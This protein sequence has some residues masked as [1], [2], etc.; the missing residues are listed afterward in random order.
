MF[1]EA[2]KI[3]LEAFGIL[4]SALYLKIIPMYS[5]SKHP[6]LPTRNEIQENS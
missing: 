3:R 5:M 1:K 6:K 4:Q 2:T